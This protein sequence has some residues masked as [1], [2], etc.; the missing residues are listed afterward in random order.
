MSVG[1]LGTFIKFQ[2]LQKVGEQESQRD[3]FLGRQVIPNTHMSE[4]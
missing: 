1:E 2:V 3:L 4:E